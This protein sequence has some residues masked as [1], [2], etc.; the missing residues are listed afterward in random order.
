MAERWLVLLGCIT[1]GSVGLN[2]QV[3]S[4]WRAA[5]TAATTPGKAWHPWRVHRVVALPP[6]GLAA[7]L[8]ADMASE[9]VEIVHYLPQHAVIVS[10]PRDILGGAPVP[11]EAKWSPQLGVGA[12]FQAA[13]GEVLPRTVLV[14]FYP[15]VDPNDA[16]ALITAGQLAIHDHPD[17]LPW[18]FLVEGSDEALRHLTEWDEVAYI[19]PAAEALQKGEPLRACAGALTEYGL[20]GQAVAKMGEGWDGAGKNATQLRYWIRNFAQRLGAETTQAEILRAFDEWSKHVQVDFV[21]GTKPADTRQIDIA[22]LARSHGD[23]YAFDGPG[24]VLAHTFFPAPPNSEP[25]AGDLHFDLE[26]AWAVS[27]G[28]PD[29]FTVTLHELGHALGLGH[30]DHPSAVMY[31]YYRRATAL[32]AEDINAIRDLYAARGSD[33]PPATPPANPPATPP[34]TP[35]SPPPATPPATPPSTPPQTPPATP[36]PPA[37]RT[38]PSL[39]ITSPSVSVYSTSADQ[40]TVRGTAKD[41]VGVTK[42]TWTT[43]TGGAGTASGTTSWV[44]DGILLYKGN[45]T[46][47]VRAWDAAGNSTWRSIIV[48]RR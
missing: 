10:G 13:A 30:S 28:D 14:E 9:G 20:V 43:N 27:G 19:F 37:D 26:E 1:L 3:K 45:T 16:R 47:I 22:F 8:Q 6:E 41:N 42:V 40:I 23:G 7:A 12:H 2:A 35:P 5:T 48:T 15:D 25:I 34:A 39:T 18:H 11:P 36:P 17:L 38:A 29:L 32:T 24:R 4:P 21:A 44:A 33:A 31:A 46:I